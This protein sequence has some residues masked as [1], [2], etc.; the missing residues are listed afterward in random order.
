[1]TMQQLMI[2]VTVT[3]RQIEEYGHASGD[4]NPLHMDPEAAKKEG[5]R[6][7]IVHGLLMMGICWS[8]ITETL[9]QKPE[10]LSAKF[11]DIVYPDE[12]LLLELEVSSDGEGTGSLT[13]PDGTVK[14]AL[15]FGH[16]GGN[17]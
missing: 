2:P 8:R 9:G 5:Y 1:M 3:S 10:R 7:Q 14:V 4:L 6:D 11:K 13:G 17:P 16:K 15:E 12:Q